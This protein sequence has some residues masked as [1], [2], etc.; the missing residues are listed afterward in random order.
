MSTEP[1][2]QENQATPSVSVNGNA[3]NNTVQTSK[4]TDMPN[5]PKQEQ[6]HAHEHGGDE[7]CSACA[8]EKNGVQ[9]GTAMEKDN[10]ERIIDDKNVTNCN[11]VHQ[12]EMSQAS[13]CC[14]DNM[15]NNSNGNLKN[16]ALVG[17]ICYLLSIVFGFTSFISVV[18]G[19]VFKSDAK[20]T[21]FESH[22][23]YIRRTFWLYILYGLL[24]VGVFG[25]LIITPFAP[26][27]VLLGFL[28]MIWVLVRG[29]KG[30]KDLSNNKPID[31]PKTWMF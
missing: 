27:V 20:G 6:E 19:Y 12:E 25:V 5:M 31:N 15:D 10:K 9:T 7:T 30:I 14:K 3:T 2:K 26:L 21:I 29:I 18:V 11:G 1:N 28:L 24:M 16:W 23:Q 22:F 17:H 13:A 8:L 4:V